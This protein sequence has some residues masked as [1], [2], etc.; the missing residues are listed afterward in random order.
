MSSMSHHKE[1]AC[2]EQ[3]DKSLRLDEMLD[4]EGLRFAE[5]ELA[6][7]ISFLSTTTNGAAGFHARGRELDLFLV[8]QNSSR[9]KNL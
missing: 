5:L 4:T 2:V 7:E 6:Q 1:Q 3:A 8:Q 9:P